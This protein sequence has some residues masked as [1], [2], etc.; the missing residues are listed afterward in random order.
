ME[1]RDLGDH[2]E[3]F[4]IG[5]VGREA[6]AGGR[7]AFVV[8]LWDVDSKQKYY[9]E[10]GCKGNRYIQKLA[11]RFPLVEIVERSDGPVKNTETIIVK[12]KNVEVFVPNENN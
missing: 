5:Q 1:Y 6:M 7:I 9:G 4:R 8:D 10:R 2:S 12:R 3:D 11:E